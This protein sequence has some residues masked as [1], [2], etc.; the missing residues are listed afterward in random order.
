MLNDINDYAQKKMENG[1][2]KKTFFITTSEEDAAYYA[3]LAKIANI[4]PVPKVMIDIFARALE[5]LY[6]NYPDFRKDIYEIVD[7]E[8]FTVRCSN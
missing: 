2:R 6:H 4:E 8:T 3:E 5:T 7:S 1:Y